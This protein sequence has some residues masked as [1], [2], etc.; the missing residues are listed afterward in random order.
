MTITSKNF[1]EYNFSKSP[2]ASQLSKLTV[3]KRLETVQ[4]V[5]VF[6]LQ[7]HTVTL[8]GSIRLVIIN[9]ASS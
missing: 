8:V 1:E 4:P 5:P 9:D 7:D 6:E 2:L 3:H